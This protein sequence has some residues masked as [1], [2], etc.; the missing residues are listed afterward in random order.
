MFEMSRGFWID[1]HGEAMHEAWICD[2]VVYSGGDRYRFGRQLEIV[3]VGICFELK[4][5]ELLFFGSV[6]LVG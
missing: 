5:F 6:V 4:D 1:G 2:F 3:E